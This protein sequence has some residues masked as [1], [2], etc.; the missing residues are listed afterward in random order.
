MDDR[1]GFANFE[2]ESVL[3]EKLMKV[4]ALSPKEALDA[5]ADVMDIEVEATIAKINCIMATEYEGEGIEIP[6]EIVEDGGMDMEHRIRVLQ[7]FFDRGWRVRNIERSNP[8]GVR[9]YYLF[10]PAP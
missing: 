4:Q 3:S 7:R 9:Y 5:F 6:V 8:D 2:P 10:H 1:I